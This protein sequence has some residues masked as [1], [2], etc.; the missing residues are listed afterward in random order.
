MTK[1]LL[2]ATI[3]TSADHCNFLRPLT[4]L[5]AFITGEGEQRAEWEFSPTIS[6]AQARCHGDERKSF[7]NFPVTQPYVPNVHE[8]SCEE[9]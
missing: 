5:A 8:R 6:P 7:T 3:V 1:R 2:S 4:I 9:K